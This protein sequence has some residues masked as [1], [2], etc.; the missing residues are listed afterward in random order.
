MSDLFIG[1]LATAGLYVESVLP[2]YVYDINCTGEE[3][4]IMNCRVNVNTNPTCG[5]RQDAS[6]Q[7]QGNVQV[8]TCTIERN[9]YYEMPNFRHI[10][11]AGGTW[12]RIG[13]NFMRF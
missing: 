1:A 2:V 12:Y 10:E 5:S 4:S 8:H 6:V 3:E 13:L 9:I 7:C 11:D